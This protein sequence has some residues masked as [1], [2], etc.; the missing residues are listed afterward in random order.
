MV[1]TGNGVTCPVAIFCIPV[2][3]NV[4]NANDI[5]VY[6]GAQELKATKG[7]ATQKLCAPTSTRWMKE[8]VQFKSSYEKFS[9]YVNNGTP[10]EWYERVKHL[11]N[12]Y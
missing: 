6:V 11:D 9:G 2:A 4:D 12:L 3:D 5:P 1:N 7:A 8:R 10:K